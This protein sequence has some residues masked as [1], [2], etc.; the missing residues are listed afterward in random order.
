MATIIS[1]SA[2]ETFEIGRRFAEMVK[3]GDVLALCGDL[4][5][6]KTHFVKGLARGLDCHGE[7]TSPTFTLVHEYVGG[8]L[9]LY[10]I[11]LYRLETDDE[12]LRIGFD[13]YLDSRGV[14]AVEW[15][16]KFADLMPPI[17][18]WIRIAQRGEHEREIEI[19]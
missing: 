4:G 5:A 8:R 14:A 2:E 17:T 3:A 13:E 19:G 18:R 9:S 6:G 10:H 15:A 16:D 12:V 1:H 11:D 7:A